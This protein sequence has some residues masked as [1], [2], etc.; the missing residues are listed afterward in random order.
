MHAPGFITVSRRFHS[1]ARVLVTIWALLDR[2]LGADVAVGATLGSEE[3]TM[4]C[5]LLMHCREPA[6]GGISEDVDGPFAETKEAL[7]GVFVLDVPDLDAAIGWA[8]RG[9]GGGPRRLRHRLGD[10]RVPLLP[11]SRTRRADATAGR[12]ARPVSSWMPVGSWM[13]SH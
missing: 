3:L 12:C 4:R 6:E 7:A 10:R 13:E 9:P 2:H 11:A 5:A 8:G 1:L